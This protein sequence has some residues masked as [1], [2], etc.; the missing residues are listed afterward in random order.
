MEESENTWTASSVLP[1]PPPPVLRYLPEKVVLSI[2]DTERCHQILRAKEKA[3]DCYQ[4]GTCP[5]KTLQDLQRY[6]H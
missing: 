5:K 1:P 6:Y 2:F 4:K 3:Q